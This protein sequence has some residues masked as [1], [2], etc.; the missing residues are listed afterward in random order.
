[1]ELFSFRKQTRNST[2]LSRTNRSELSETGRITWESLRIVHV[3]HR[4]N[5]RRVEIYRWRSKKQELCLYWRHNFRGTYRP[6]REKTERWPTFSEI[7]RKRTTISRSS[8]SSIKHLWTNHSHSFE[9]CA[10]NRWVGQKLVS[11]NLYINFLTYI[12]P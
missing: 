3:I 5:H 10:A 1:M 6:I 2:N 12:R 4:L 8:L 7:T 9:E 11:R